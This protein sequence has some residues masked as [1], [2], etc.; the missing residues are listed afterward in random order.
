MPKRLAF[1]LLIYA[2]SKNV[3]AQAINDSTFYRS[4]ASIIDVYYMAALGPQ[5]P[6][7]NGIEYIDYDFTLREG[8]P[9]FESQEFKNGEIY[10]DGMMFYKVPMCYDLVK[11][12]VVIRDFYNI[13]KIVL[14]ANKI[15][16][17]ALA[18]HTFVRIQRDS[19]NQVKTGFYDQL[20]KGKIGL[21]AKREKEI[22]EKSG[23]SG[24]D[25][26]VTSKNTYHIMKGGIY[27]SF[28]NKRG[29]LD[30]LHDKKKA[31]Q[32][33]FKKNKIRFKDNPEKAMIA[34]VEYCNRLIN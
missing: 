11:D 33:Y 22:F 23:F 4:I 19:L 16:Q 15:Q 20:C 17:F 32:Q 10:F 6:I 5:S 27:Y 34:A 30:I 13:Y 18:G 3:T 7:Y 26:L 24:I 21:F 28:K 14:P 9:F 25:I 1:L 31:I 12:Q 8:H 2:S 29:L